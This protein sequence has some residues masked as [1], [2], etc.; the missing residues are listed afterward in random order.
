MTR[1]SF[2]QFSHENRTAEVWKTGEGYEVDLMENGKLLECRQLYSH[3]ESFAEDCADN[4]CQ[5]MFNVEK[6]GS[7]YGYK[8]R[9]EN[10][11]PGLDD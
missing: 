11:Y 8:E 3:S 7:F 6:E 1:T 4:W 9:N 5:G 10:F 2:H